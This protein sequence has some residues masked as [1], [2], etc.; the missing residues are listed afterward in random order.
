MF[1]NTLVAAAFAIVGFVPVAHAVS[2]SDVTIDTSIQVDGQVEFGFDTDLNVIDFFGDDSF[3]FRTGLSPL[4]GPIEISGSTGVDPITGAPAPFVFGDIVF[5]NANSTVF[6]TVLDIAYGNN[7]VGGLPGIQIL[8]QQENTSFGSLSTDFT[9]LFVVNIFEFFG[10]AQVS[11]P[12][13]LF[14]I[15]ANPGDPFDQGAIAINAV[16]AA[17]VPLPAPLGLL[18]AGIL[19]L[20]FIRRRFL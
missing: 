3:G 18:L 4:A 12:G 14:D 20:G 5:G 15:V 2:L 11:G 16:E 17:V 19:S 10:S 6:G 9:T 7:V 8:Y 1:R 13:D